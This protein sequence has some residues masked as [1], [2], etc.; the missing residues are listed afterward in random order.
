MIEILVTTRGSC[1]TRNIHHL[2]ST[3]QLACNCW[4]LVVNIFFRNFMFLLFNGLH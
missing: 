3:V 4:F 1:T 2:R